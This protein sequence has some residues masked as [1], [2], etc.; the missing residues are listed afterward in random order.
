MNTLEG[1][2]AI[3]VPPCA[4]IGQLGQARELFRAKQ[5][6][7]AWSAALSA[8]VERPY[9]PE[10]YLLLAETAQA[11]G[12]ASSARRCAKAARDMAPGWAPPKN[13][14][15][16]DMRGG[17]RPSWLKMPPALDEHLAAA[18]PRVSVCLIVKDEESFLP[19]CLRS[20]RALASQ[21]IVVD[22][23]ST[24]RT[25]EIAREFG[26]EVHSFPWCDDFS[27]ARNA[28]LEHATGD[29]ILSLDADEELMPKQ[30]SI[31]SRE[32]QAANVMGYRLPIL[33]SGHEQQGCGYVPRLFRNAPGLFYVG[34]I[35]EQAFSSIEACCRQWG[36]KHELGHAALLHHGFT[37]EVLASRN[38]V[39]RN[40]RLLQRSIEEEPGEPNLLMHLGLELVRSGKLEA[41]LDRYW[42]AFRLISA[43]PIA[44]VAPEWREE[45]LTQLATH[46]MAARRFSDIVGLWE[47]PFA[48]HGGLTAAQHF[49][50]AV[51]LREIKQPAQAAEQIGHCLAKRDRPSFAPI[52]PEIHRAGPHHCLALCLI[53]LKDTAGAQR[54]FDSALAA[55]PTCRPARFDLARFQAAQGRTGEA[56]Q[57]LR[58]MAAENPSE[59]RVWELGGQIA[60]SRPEHLLFAREWTDEAV[61]HFPENT[62]LLGQRAEALLLNQDVAQALPLW[63]RAQAAGSPRQI[64]AVILC[65]LLMGDRQYH[66]TAAE[67][68]ALSGEVLQWYRQCI[69]MGAQALIQQM[70]ERMET[71]RLTLPAFVRVL[72]AAHRQARQA[73]V[74]EARA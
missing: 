47:T 18:V 10:A 25:S 11:A 9:H 20:I 48:S 6:P 55:E 22:T 72:E 39:E 73:V 62:H 44:T 63:R 27:A 57:V 8:I 69:R 51:A 50:L 17:A 49:S 31:L 42:E 32:I 52:P 21:I 67:E 3:L 40:L 66:F 16:G 61:K 41:G 37:I 24:D 70:H 36:L 53:A 43:R 46:L 71:M 28:A 15:R 74:S 2:S 33:S 60:L 29:W 4:L 65:E 45:F 19:Q 7:N 64:A 13:F 58:H 5:W 12:D 26:A 59:A 34:R 14:L 38:K 23:G 35:H 56:L 30:G 68:P 1:P 54:A